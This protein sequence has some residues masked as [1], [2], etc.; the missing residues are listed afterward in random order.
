MRLVVCAK[1]ARRCLFAERWECMSVRS[2][3]RVLVPS[4]CLAVR[5]CVHRCVRRYDKDLLAEVPDLLQFQCSSFWELYLTGS[6]HSSHERENGGL[7]PSHPA[8][9]SSRPH[10]YCTLLPGSLLFSPTTTTQT[11]PISDLVQE[12]ADRTCRRRRGPEL[13]PLESKVCHERRKRDEDWQQLP[14]AD[15]RRGEHGG[16]EESFEL[17]LARP[18]HRGDEGVLPGVHLH[19]P[20]AGEE[21]RG[22]RTGRE[23]RRKTRSSR[24]TRST[25]R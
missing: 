11:P 6:A 25:R 8:P 10:S 9:C 24:T 13:S 19:Q 16:V 14:T 4:V 17:T 15:V 22:Q 1:W 3:V 18:L 7:H 20:H 21:L 5:A 2:C 23:S 12:V